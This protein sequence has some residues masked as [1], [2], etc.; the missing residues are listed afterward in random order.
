MAR[1]KCKI[2][3]SPVVT[4]PER[5]RET[6]QE[7]RARLVCLSHRL[8]QREWLSFLSFWG[9]PHTVWGLEA[10]ASGVRSIHCRDPVSGHYAH[11]F[12]TI[13]SRQIVHVCADG[14]RQDCPSIQSCMLTTSVVDSWGPQC[15]GAC[16]AM[17]AVWL[18]TQSR[19]RP[20]YN[21]TDAPKSQRRS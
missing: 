18:N 14:K 17:S 4:I 6:K 3:S 2:S 21:R 8:W 12:Q 20:Q 9:P 5:M 11:C 7:R 19:F 13:Q 1:S 16:T 15:S 10:A